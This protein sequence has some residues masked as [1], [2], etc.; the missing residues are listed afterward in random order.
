LY[1]G[2]DFLLLLLDSTNN[3]SNAPA[4]E[5]MVGKKI[6]KEQINNIHHNT[7][8][9]TKCGVDDIGRNNAAAKIYEQH[10]VP[11]IFEPFVRDQISLLRSW[12]QIILSGPFFS[13]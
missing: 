3:F 10:L 7:T 9:W 1:P 12:V 4:S 8:M 11:A 5:N 2:K 13:L 6:K